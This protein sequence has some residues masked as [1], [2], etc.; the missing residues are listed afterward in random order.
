MHQFT[1]YLHWTLVGILY[2][3]LVTPLL[4]APQFLFPFI[5]TKT[6]FFRLLVELG[7]LI[8]AT[9]IMLSPAS[10]KP[11]MNKL[12]WAVV[13]FGIII[14][15]TGLTGADFYK[16]FWGTIE[17]GE[18]FL[19]LSHLIVYFLLL[20]WLFKTKNDWLNYF[21]GAVVVSLLV[22]FY[23]LLQRAEVKSFFLF[24]NI[25]HSGEG[26]LSATIGNAS[27]LANYTLACFFL[28]ALLF[29]QRPHWGWKIFAGLAALLN[30][31]ILFQTQTRGALLALIFTLVLLAIIYVLKSSKK[32]VK[33]ISSGILITLVLVSLFIWLNKD[34]AWVKKVPALNRLVSISKTDVTTESRLAAWQASW[35]GWKDRFILGYGWENYNIA[36]NKYFP[37]IIYKD[38]GSQLWFDRAHNTIFDVAVATG[39]IGLINYL[40]IFGLA[41]Y[42]LFKK[43]K[44]D[45]HTSAILMALLISHFLQNIFVFDVL[46]TF[47][48]L[49]LV[50]A[51]IARPD[52]PEESAENE[53]SPANLKINTSQIAA[54]VTNLIIIIL[55]GL[56]FKLNVFILSSFFI[57]VAGALLIM[58]KKTSARENILNQLNVNHYLGLIIILIL[59]TSA[60]YFFNFKPLQ[61]NA[62]AVQA[63]S[64]AAT[65]QEKIA[66]KVFQQAIQMN[67]YQTPE[68]R[69]KLADNILTYNKTKNGLTQAEVINNFQ[70]CIQALRDNLSEHPTDVQNHLYLMAVLNQA[71]VLDTR[72]LDS[73]LAVGQ[74]ATKLSPTRPQIYFEMGQALATLKKYQ[75]ALEYFKQG[76]A[77][78]PQTA[79]SHWN[80][81]AIYL[82][83][84]DDKKAQEEYNFLA[85][86]GY[87]FNSAAILNRLYNVY[88]LANRIEKLVD[89]M[90]KLIKIE[91]TASN[92]ARL[93]AVYYQI[94]DHQNARLA[95]Q[96]AV[97][98][99]PSLAAEAEKFLET[100]K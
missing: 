23:A 47:I 50:L 62:T 6:M 52:Q 53:E 69:Q 41:L 48:I 12:S 27:F 38:S 90:L 72:Y 49:F 21:T 82:I 88:L 33:C 28:S 29:F 97:E 54:L 9:L 63:L 91:P 35:R 89:V 8:Y 66:V 96:K 2:L 79:E 83:I 34:S 75:E 42:Y 4:L 36:F 31:Y 86:H 30:L 60:T 26:R 76:V 44:V 64:A 40:I 16:T 80:L 73:M 32:T 43:I 25:I 84:K 10:Y 7:I 99:D 92:Y 74:E 51:F 87:N 3:I 45:F 77:L 71:A 55:L 17:R 67:T 1:K 20:S 81:M 78:N 18:G 94:G 100:L 95:V 57:L 93:A 68:L 85:Q 98:L 59:F 24:G 46:S 15:F 11:R 65:N 70:I 37:A 19:T 58:A 39:L 13:I 14:F 5:T 61:A 56:V 22:D